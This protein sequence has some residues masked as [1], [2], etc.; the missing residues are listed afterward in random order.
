MA[1]P[2]IKIMPIAELNTEIALEPGLPICDA[3]H[4]LWERAPHR[5]QLEV[6]NFAAAVR[7]EEPALLG[8]ADA[9]GQARALGALLASVR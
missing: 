6:E 2:L 9:V 8:R 7:G 5:Y 4:H 1:D 3:H